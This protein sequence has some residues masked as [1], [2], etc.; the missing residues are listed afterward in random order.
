PRSEARRLVAWEWRRDAWKPASAAE[1]RGLITE[2]MSAR[3]AWLTPGARAFSP[4]M[5]R[6]FRI[7]AHLRVV[8]TR[9]VEEVPRGATGSGERALRLLGSA[10]RKL[11]EADGASGMTPADRRRPL[12][13]LHGVVHAECLEGEL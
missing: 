1:A 10:I 12:I 3:S 11:V 6:R 9:Y 5:P 8:L 4:A 7:G 2:L 13:R